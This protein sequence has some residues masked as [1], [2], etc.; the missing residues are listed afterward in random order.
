MNQPQSM[1]ELHRALKTMQAST[2]AVQ[3]AVQA[4]GDHSRRIA[5]LEDTMAQVYPHVKA[6]RDANAASVAAS[7]TGASV[8]AA[9]RNH[10]AEAREHEQT[11]T[12]WL[13]NPHSYDARADVL[14][15]EEAVLGRSPRAASSASG[16]EGG[17]AVPAPIFERIQQRILEISP[18]RRLA[19]TYEV[20]STGTSFLID[21]NDAAS[22][23]VGETDERPET[24]E[25]TLGRR[26]PTFGIVYGR[27]KAT[28]ELMA[29]SAVD[30]GS[31]FTNAAAQQIAY[32][33]GA[34]FV[35]GN[36][37]KKPTG[38][39]NGTPVATGDAT[40][41]DGVLQ[42]VP[43]LDSESFVLDSLT[44][45]FFSMKA[46][47][48]QSGTWLM[49]SATASVIAKMKDGEARPLWQPSISAETPPSLLG[50]PVVFDE[51]MPAIAADAFPIAFGNFAA[52]YLI[53]DSFGLRVTVDDNI[54]TPGYIKWY[55]R[56]RVG[57]IILDDDAIKL[58]KV[59]TT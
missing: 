28:E 10:S 7:A 41:D 26:V 56:R 52:G 53:A 35:A 45:L 54:T 29:D 3:Q 5:E 31:W 12:K 25:T 8:P 47:H 27:V 55:I 6:L 23:W 4:A 40:R 36:G 16:P 34:A 51:N 59:A 32:A 39:L 20:T 17:F 13:R 37:T 11:F 43:T 44:T 30:I 58:L 42:Y 9:A 21:Q 38:F 1:Q 48:R 57:G 49:N 14:A 50:R 19:T 33:E 24:D 15:A 2:P 18:M 46:M 22:N